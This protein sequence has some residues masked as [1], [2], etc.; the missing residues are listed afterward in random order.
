[1]RDVFGRFVMWREPAAFREPGELADCPPARFL[2]VALPLHRVLANLPSCRICGD[3][4]CDMQ[5]HERAAAGD[6]DCRG[7]AAR[8]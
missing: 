8:P 7:G 2:P 4:G 3:Y 6:E 1:M 5:R